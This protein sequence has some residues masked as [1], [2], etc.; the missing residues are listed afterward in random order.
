MKCTC[1][2]N[3]NHIP[4]AGAGAG[5]GHYSLVLG[6]WPSQ[7]ISLGLQTF[8]DTNMLVP[9]T[10]KS[11]VGGIAQCEPQREWVHIAVEYRLYSGESQQGC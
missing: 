8:L 2:P 3:A 10:Q 1:I 7:G 5:I 9:A 4:L 11:H 6:I